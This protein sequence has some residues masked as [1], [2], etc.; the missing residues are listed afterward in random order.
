[1][2]TWQLHSGGPPEEPSSMTGRP[3][4]SG[5]RLRAAETTPI[6]PADHRVTGSGRILAKTT[7]RSH[8]YDEGGCLISRHSGGPRGGTSMRLLN[9]FRLAAGLVRARDE[10]QEGDGEE[11]SGPRPVPCASVKPG[12]VLPPRIGGPG[13]YPPLVSDRLCSWWRCPWTASWSGWWR[14]PGRPCRGVPFCVAAVCAP[15]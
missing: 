2:N 5:T 11:G 6:P 12:P 4:L 1:M 9:R 8:L 15:P 10:I 7:H 13:R 3:G 14:W